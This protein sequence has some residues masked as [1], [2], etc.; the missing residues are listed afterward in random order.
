MHKNPFAPPAPS[1]YN[2]QQ[3]PLPPGPPPPQPAQPDYSAYW[4]AAAASAAQNPQAAATQA[5][6]PQWSVPQPPQQVVPR[7]PPEQSALYANYGYGNQHWQQQQQRP[8]QQHFQ[9]PPPVV[10][11]PPPPPQQGYNPY[12]PQAGSYQQPYVPQAAPPHAIPQVPYTP[13]APSV[14]TFQPQQQFFPNQQQNRNNNRNL[15]QSPSQHLPPAKRQRFDGPNQQRGPPPPPQFQPPPPM[16]M[17]QQPPSGPGGSNLGMN[18]QNSGHGRGGGPGVNQLPLGG[19]RGGFGGGRGGNMGG[20]RGRG[21]GMGMN[22]GGNRGG[23]GGGMYNNMG[24]RGGGPGQGGNFRGQGNRGFGSRDNRRGGSFNTGAGPSFPHGNQSQ[25]Q[26]QHQQQQQHGPQNFSGSFRGRNQGY[27][28]SHGRGGRHDSGAVH[29]D[30]SVSSAVSSGKKEENR[31]TLTDFKI[32]GLEIQDLGWTW[33]SVPKVTG[34]SGVKEES[35]ESKVSLPVENAES[36]SPERKLVESD[37]GTEGP[38]DAAATTHAAAEQSIVSDTSTVK[39][40]SGSSLPP[41]P[42]RIRIYFH[43]PVTADDAHALS[44]QPSI[45]HGSSSESS[46]RKGKRKKLEDDDDGDTEDGRGPPPP[47]PQRSGYDHESHAS[48]SH[49]CDN[50]DAATGRG[51]VSLSVVETGSEGDWLLAAIGEDEHEGGDGDHHHGQDI[52]DTDAEGEPDDYDGH[53]Y[54]EVDAQME[55]VDSDPSHFSAVA[56]DSGSMPPGLGNHDDT[57]HESSA[58]SNGAS[59]GGSDSQPPPAVSDENAPTAPPS[60]EAG[61]YCPTHSA[62]PEPAVDPVPQSTT[63]DADASSSAQTQA[64]D[65]FSPSFDPLAWVVSPT[66]APIREI[67]GQESLYI[68]STQVDEQQHE[69]PDLAPS[70]EPTQLLEP[71][72]DVQDAERPPSSETSSATLNVSPLPPVGPTEEASEYIKFDA[73]NGHVPSANRL[74]ISF[75]GGSRRMVIDSGVVE[76]L[77]VFRS[78]ARIEVYISVTEENGH[79]KG[80]LVEG[81]SEGSAS[82]TA[83]EIPQNP[84]DDKTVPPFRK[85]SLPPQTVLVAYLDKERPLSEPRWVKTGDVQE[86]L[87]SMF[88]RMFW[89]AGD[90]A[91]GWEKKI[92]VVDPDPPPTIWTVLEAW[93]VNSNVGVQSERQRFLRTHMAETDNI[94]EILLRLVRGERASYSQPAPALSAPSVSG[95]LL[96]AL[97]PG[98]AHGAQQTHVSLAV[99]AIFRLSVEFARKADGDDGKGEVEERVGEIIRCLPSHLIYKSLDGIFKEWRVEKKGGR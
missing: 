64:D 67:S 30:S 5:Y 99:L 43:T 60:S 12:Q 68:T 39:T 8:T 76:K 71:P 46:T 89:V 33:G 90:A 10:Q 26:S 16:P 13:Q 70:A 14:H 98:S 28:N 50:A 40:E 77:K 37:A 83:L 93:A 87:K 55:M 15:H 74:S 54:D 9:P 73:D 32:V 31:R 97:S 65:L 25:H 7:P 34:S 56:H 29:K 63:A 91:D 44:S 72:P 59:N 51:S 22:R 57:S 69:H 27:A 94:L 48:T 66:H 11:P 61:A 23:R 52:G 1:A 95:P 79:L 20:G 62:V 58:L 96:S 36:Q 17:Q 81:T 85:T 41:P 47:P 88:G 53:D 78:D 49:D 82:Y 35:D 19:N 24:G 45:S 3:P 92:E 2:P 18:G 86:W 6:N 42:S 75:A 80:I 4:A 21:V 38:A 84:E